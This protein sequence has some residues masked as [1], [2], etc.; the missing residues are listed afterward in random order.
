MLFEFYHMV[1]MYIIIYLYTDH[2]FSSLRFCFIKY[3]V[4][5]Q[6]LLDVK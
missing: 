3:P 5:R 2:I 4:K 1:K 6:E